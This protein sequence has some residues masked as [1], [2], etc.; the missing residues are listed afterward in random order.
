MDR[1]PQTSFHLLSLDKKPYKWRF[2][3]GNIIES[4]NSMS[5]FPASHAWVPDDKHNNPTIY[6]YFFVFPHFFA[7]HRCS[8]SWSIPLSGIRFWQCQATAGALRGPM[9]P[10]HLTRAS[11]NKPSPTSGERHG[12]GW[13]ECWQ[14]S[15]HDRG[16][17]WWT[18][19]AMENHHF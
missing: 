7:E 5:D 11:W 19:I 18:N 10:R 3:T 17:L 4:S 2:I 12:M 1:C 15:I 16:T 6:E 9:V 8:L 13:D 14:H